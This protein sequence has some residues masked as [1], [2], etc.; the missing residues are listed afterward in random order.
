MRLRPWHR[1]LVVAVLTATGLS[2][3]FWYVLHDLMDRGPSD[4]LHTLLVVHGVAAFSTA[5]AFGSLLPVHVLVGSRQPRNR[6]SGLVLATVVGI[7]ITTALILYYGSEELRDW[8]RLIHLVVGFAAIAVCGAHLAIGRRI[9]RYARAERHG[10][11]RP[12]THR[13]RHRTVDARAD[14]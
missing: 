10:V 4:T 14:D 1:W 12:D 5:V 2:G 11:F 7:L 9:R 6:L 3:A 13:T 8:G